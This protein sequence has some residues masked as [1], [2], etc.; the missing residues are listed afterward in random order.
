MFVDLDWPL[1]ASSLLSASAELLVLYN[2]CCFHDFI[3]TSTPIE[4]HWIALIHYKNDVNTENVFKIAAVRHQEFGKISTLGHVTSIGVWFVIS[5]CVNRPI[6][7]RN[8]A[9]NDFQYSI[10]PPFWI[11]KNFD[12]FVKFPC[13]EFVYQIWSKS[14]NSQLKY[15][16]KAIFKMAA[17]RHLEFF[18]IGVLVTCPVLACE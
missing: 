16:D 2:I 14:D 10:R 15:G 12:F 3:E 4:K 1:N 9:K 8:I 18:K 11:W 6:R 13:S 17:V 5:I 7:R